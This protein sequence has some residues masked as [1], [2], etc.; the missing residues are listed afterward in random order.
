MKSNPLKLLTLILASFLH[1]SLAFSEIEARHK[2]KDKPKQN[3]A[4][5]EVVSL[6]AR[7]QVAMQM[8]HHGIRHLAYPFDWIVTS[9]Q[10]LGSFITNH[11]SHFL[12]LDKVIYVEEYAGNPPYYFVKDT[13]YNFES[14]HDFLPPHIPGNFEVVKDKFQRR[15]KRFFALLG[16]DK[17][18]L[19]LRTDITRQ[20]AEYLDNIIHTVYP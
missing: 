11:G 4:Y 8:E 3:A 2:H 14:Y 10:G 5:D 1:F 13:H 19:F 16:S 17:K 20:D 18:V 6:G 15:I 12:D 9:A 7:C